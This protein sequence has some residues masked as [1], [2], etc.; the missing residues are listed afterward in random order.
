MEFPCGNLLLTQLHLR[1]LCSPCLQ[2]FLS[3]EL[4]PPV[5][6]RTSLS[7]LV[8]AQNC[9]ENRRRGKRSVI[10]RYE[11]YSKKFFESRG[12]CIFNWGYKSTRHPVCRGNP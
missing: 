1:I 10:E 7:R 3:E 11:H 5:S 6:S 8:G 2:R 4:V 12:S 9:A